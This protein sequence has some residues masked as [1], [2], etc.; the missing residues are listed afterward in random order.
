MDNEA[1]FRKQEFSKKKNPAFSWVTRVVFFPD[2][3][4][5]D[6]KSPGLMNVSNY[7]RHTRRNKEI[8]TT[9]CQ[10]CCLIIL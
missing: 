9:E 8:M 5:S 7:R 4:K 10:T 2:F 1:G 3:I 6:E